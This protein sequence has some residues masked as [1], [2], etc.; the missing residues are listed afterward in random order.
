M[1]IQYA[2]F[3]AEAVDDMPDTMRSAVQEAL[4]GSPQ[5]VALIPDE[6]LIAERNSDQA[7]IRERQARSNLI[8]QRIDENKLEKKTK[9]LTP[10]Q[11]ANAEATHERMIASKRTKGFNLGVLANIHFYIFITLSSVL[12]SHMPW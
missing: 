10:E 1:F 12:G 7:I 6:E 4:R 2:E 9:T 8:Q 11:L 5:E 3:Y